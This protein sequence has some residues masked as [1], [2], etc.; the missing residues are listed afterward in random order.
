MK[1]QNELF[2]LKTKNSKCYYVKNNVGK[3]LIVTAIR[4]EF[5]YCKDIEVTYRSKHK[6]YLIDGY[7]DVDYGTSGKLYPSKEYYEDKEAATILRD[8]LIKELPCRLSTLQKIEALII[9]ENIINKNVIE[10]L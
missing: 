7:E 8:K 2:R 6:F 4:G 9:N 10:T 3:E 1:K 5:I